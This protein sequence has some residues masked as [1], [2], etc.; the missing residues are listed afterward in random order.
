MVLEDCGDEGD[1]HIHPEEDPKGYN[2]P[3][4]SGGVAVLLDAR[5]D[6][7]YRE[8]EGLSE[9]TILSAGSWKAIGD[10]YWNEKRFCWMIHRLGESPRRHHEASDDE[11]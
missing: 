7:R 11:S 1:R 4:A 10:T 9:V 3:G 2:E 8:E 5:Y 6:G